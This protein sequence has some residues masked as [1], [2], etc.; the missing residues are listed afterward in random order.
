MICLCIFLLSGCTSQFLN[1]DKEDVRVAENQKEYNL[2]VTD[3][4]LSR[5]MENATR[6]SS[7]LRNYFSDG[8]IEYVDISYFQGLQ[9]IDDYTKE[10]RDELIL[11]AGENNMTLK[12]LSDMIVKIS[13]FECIDE[14]TVEVVT[15]IATETSNKELTCILQGGDLVEVSFEN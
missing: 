15:Q 4:Q 2:G 12:Q 6:L 14:G 13:V 3:N 9:Y 10:L 1:E 11:I 7:D 8:D 5:A